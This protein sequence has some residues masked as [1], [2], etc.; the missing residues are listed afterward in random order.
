MRT[1]KITGS[2]SGLAIY[3]SR[4][5]AVLSQS[6]FRWYWLSSSTQG[7]AIGTQFLVIGWLVLEVTESSAQLGLVI[8]LYG[9][10]NVAFLLIAGVIADRFDR[11]YLLIATQGSVAG[12][13]TVL[14]GLTVADM[15]AIWHVY[16]AAFFMGLVQSL[17]M[18]ARFAIIGDIVKPS[19]I[20]DAVAMQNMAVHLG[21]MIGP[22]VAGVIIE[23][24]GVGASLGVVAA[25]Y[26]ASVGFVKRIGKLDRPTRADT[27]SVVRNFSS[28]LG[29]IKNNPMILTVIIITCAFGGFG[30]SH[31]QVVPAIAKDTLGAG[32]ADIGLLFFASGIGSLVGSL[33]LPAIEKA[34]V[35]RALLVSLLVFTVML[36]FFAWSNWFWATWVFFLLVGVTG[37]GMVWPLATTMIQLET[38]AEVRGRVLGVLQFTPGLHFLGAFPLALVAGQLGWEVAITGAAGL[39]MATTVWFALLRRGRPQLSRQE[40]SVV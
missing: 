5:P 26:V 7:L 13:I 30:M 34:H 9:A 17:S 20:L 38:S 40:A 32:A 28:G 11:R 1:I 23:V 24:W 19:L 15:V 21:R 3:W 12:V 10:P 36:S 37:V 16:T 31:M 22:P 14:T 29:Y 18:P 8:F 33:C 39:S 27:E 6:D 2:A 25:T 35:Y 4:L